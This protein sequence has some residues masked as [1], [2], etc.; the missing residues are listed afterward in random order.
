MSSPDLTPLAV[1]EFRALRATIRERGTVRWIVIALTFV[2]WASLVIVG[3]AVLPLPVIFLV[4]LVV[5]A[6]GFE[7]VFA[8]HVGAERVGRFL[9]ARYEAGPGS[10]PSWEH[11]AMATGSDPRLNAGIDPL[12]SWLFATATVLNLVP[13]ALTASDGPRIGDLLPVELI[14]WGLFHLLFLFRILRARRF[15]ASQRAI[16]LEFFQRP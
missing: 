11:A 13:I 1:E 6:A 10:L 14:V 16:E 8:L 2:A 7:I 9:Q 12:C 3:Q 5:L 15:A 4:T